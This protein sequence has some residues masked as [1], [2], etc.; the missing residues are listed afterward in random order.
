MK[1]QLYKEAEQKYFSLIESAT[2]KGV[3]LPVRSIKEDELKYVFMCSNFVSKTLIKEPEMLL[4]LV[5]SGDLLRNYQ[6]E[7]YNTKLRELD[8]EEDEK[9][10][11]KKIRLIR[12]REMVRIA[13]R[14]ITGASDPVNTMKELSFFAEA[15]IDKSVELFYNIYARRY[16]TPI[17][18]KTNLPQQL[19][20]I[21][22]GKLGGEELNFSSDVDLMFSYPEPGST[23]SKIS[24]DEFFSRVVRKVIRF[25]SEPTDYGFVFRVDTRLRPFGRSGAIVMGFDAIEDYYQSYGR[26]WERYALVKARVVGGDRKR[27][28]ELLSRLKPFVYRR[29]L[30]YTVFESLREMKQKIMEEAAQL[31]ILDNIKMGPGGIREIEF[32]VQVFQLTRGGIEPELQVQSLLGAMDILKKK[33][34]VPEE[35]C[36][37][38]TE[39]YMFLRKLENRIQE[40]EDLQ[41]HSIPSDPIQRLRLAVGMGCESWEELYEQLLEHTSYVHGQ[42]EQLLAPKHGLKT[43]SDPLYFVLDKDEGEIK[44]LLSDAGFSDAQDIARVILDLKS[45][46]SLRAI[47][48]KTMDMLKRLIATILRKLVKEEKAKEI[49]LRLNALIKNIMFRAN[50]LSLML[51]NPTVIEHLIK[52]AKESSWIISF[53]SRFPVLLDELI[54]PRNLYSPP[55]RSD[56]EKDMNYRLGIADPEDVESQMIQLSLL[57]HTNTLRVAASDIA[58]IIS[59]R[60]VS[61]YLTDIAEVV[62][63]ASMKLAWK[64]CQRKPSMKNISI[65][66]GEGFCIIGYGKLGGRELSYSSDLDLIFLHCGKTADQIAFYTKVAQQ[67]IYLLTTHTMMGKAY[68]VDTRL[69]PDGSSGVL[70]VNVESFRE[71][72]MKRAWTWEHQA[73]L[74]ARPICG[75]NKIKE[76]F[77]KIRHDALTKK[78]DKG[79][80]FKDVWDMRQKVISQL[81]KRTPGLFHLKNDPGGVIDIEFIIQFLTLLNAPSHPELLRWRSH[82]HF[83]DELERLNLVE[84]EDA[85]VLRSA[86]IQMRH[87]IHRLSLQET[88]L[89]VEESQFKDTRKKVLDI[90][91]KLS[92]DFLP[93]KDSGEK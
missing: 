63:E 27:G 72:Q 65:R 50:Y 74:R 70:A 15:C 35:V 66:E 62:L 78:R 59:V 4:D 86:Y 47:T 10:L 60:E 61:S 64:N 73:L 42:F 28:E 11:A 58:G 21:G 51:E 33:S 5:Q 3:A 92:K 52:L 76:E 54:D 24:N 14:D 19:V 8:P 80:L 89:V 45:F 38:L 91:E 20:V 30:D 2:S 13:W 39:A 46:P 18:A 32:F 22:L 68:E 12:R 87:T 55:A 6:R 53:V 83:L 9:V 1:E 48:P 77:E 88:K 25:L 41:N 36:T 93:T 75:D 29:Y 81:S 31:S 23:Y 71:Y 37:R 44:K 40:Y 67:I 90:W 79:L 85:S 43:G 34:Y 26:E 84:K 16:G 7:R 49:L 69:R 56:L 17:G 82:M 57:R